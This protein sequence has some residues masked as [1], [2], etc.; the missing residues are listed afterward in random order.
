[1]T[2][3]C[4]VLCIVSVMSILIIGVIIGIRNREDDSVWLPYAG[5]Y[6]GTATSIDKEYVEIRV[7]A[8][9]GKDEAVRNVKLRIDSYR[10]YSNRPGVWNP[11]EEM[12]RIGEEYVFYYNEI[13][14]SSEDAVMRIVPYE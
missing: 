12:P 6:I 13:A 7:A 11:K 4:I 14:G 5:Y 1:M 8:D 10:F 9:D 2:N 3:R